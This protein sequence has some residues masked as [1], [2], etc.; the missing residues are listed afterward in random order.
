MAGRSLA[1]A[2]LLT[3][4]PATATASA[5]T[6]DADRFAQ[7][8]RHAHASGTIEMTLRFEGVKEA[9][10]EAAGTCGVKGKVTTTMTLDSRRRVQSP[11]A[12]LVVL[13]GKGSIVASIT[14]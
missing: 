8:A 4:L 2:A 10:C 12:G 7:F 13:P 11:A 14:G 3:A 1:L 6:M 9:G 5:S